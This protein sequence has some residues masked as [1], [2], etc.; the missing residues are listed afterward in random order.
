M[1]DFNQYQHQ[2]YFQSLDGVR[3]LSIIA[4]IWHHSLPPDLPA[5]F[6]RGFLGVDMFFVLSGYLIVTLLLREKEKSNQKISLK[7]F[8]IRRALRIFP[9]YFGVLLAL[10][11]IYGVLKSND[12]DSEQFFSLFGIYMA[13]IANWSLVHVANLSIYW[14]LAT[15]EQFY[16]VWPIIEKICRPRITLLVLLVF[17]VINQ[18]I[19]FGIFDTLFIFLY[20]TPEVVELEILN[21]TFTPIC[22]GV[23]LAHLLHNEVW[24]K[25]AAHILSSKYASLIVLCALCMSITFSPSDLSGLP[26]LSIQFIMCIWLA[27]LVIKEGHILEGVM[28]FAPIKR[29]G[30]ISYGMYIYHMFALHI[31]REL[32]QHYGI[33]VDYYLF[34]LGFLLTIFIA[35]M[36]FRL[37]ESPILSLNKKFR[38]VP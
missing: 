34:I 21:A 13:F 12:P 5:V 2:R 31:V 9:V 15:E 24:F 17:I 14:S 35:E 37:Y 3:F 23:L 36:S 38:A 10:S 32:L 19:N 29:L 27:T 25:R 11:F 30:Q 16:I 8:Y 33:S 18:C 26:R 22:L 7:N 6:S 28:S 1:T 4:V 20:K